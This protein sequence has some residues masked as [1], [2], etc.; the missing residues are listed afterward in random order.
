MR[1]I[2]PPHIGH[3][4]CRTQAIPWERAYALALQRTEAGRKAGW[5][6]EAQ[7]KLD[8]IFRGFLPRVSNSVGNSAHRALRHEA[9]VHRYSRLQSWYWKKLSTLATIRVEY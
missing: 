4:T 5:S 3:S 6:T 7:Q 1:L 8:V 2:V 9:Q